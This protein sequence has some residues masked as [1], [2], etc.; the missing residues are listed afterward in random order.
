MKKEVGMNDE[1]RPEYD[2]SQLLKGGVRG[3]YADRYRE[4]TNLVLLSPDVAKVFP[5]E[6]AVNKALRIV[7]QLAKIPIAS[8]HKK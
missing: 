4:G 2:L 8:R 6:E 5:N 7:M 1:L 3:K